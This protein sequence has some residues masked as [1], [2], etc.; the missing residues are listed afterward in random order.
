[1]VGS[2]QAHSGA[3]YRTAYVA[4]KAG[5]VGLTRGLGFEWAKRVRPSFWHLASLISC[6]GRLWSPMGVAGLRLSSDLN[7]KR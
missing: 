1:M 7:R 5:L 6:A 3:P 4:S 2:M